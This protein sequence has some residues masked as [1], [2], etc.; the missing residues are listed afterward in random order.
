MLHEL[1]VMAA[2]ELHFIA[3]Y[4]VQHLELKS[5]YE[6]SRSLMGD[7]L[8]FPYRKVFA[9]AQ[10]LRDSKSSD[11]NCSYEARDQK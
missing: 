4:F 6:K 1:R 10:G 9:L 8:F 7:K 5:V 2:V 3:T 11:L